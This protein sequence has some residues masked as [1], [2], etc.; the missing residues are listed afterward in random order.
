MSLKDVELD[1]VDTKTHVDN[2]EVVDVDAKKPTPTRQPPPYVASLSPEE[3]E[4]V[5][6][7]LVRKIDLRLLPMII[8]MYILNYLDRNNIV[9][10]SLFFRVWLSWEFLLT[11]SLCIGSCK[12]GWSRR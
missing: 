2:V 4:K 8:I 1:T 3:R 5:E 12:T 6:R 7:A 10:L 11:V 9:S